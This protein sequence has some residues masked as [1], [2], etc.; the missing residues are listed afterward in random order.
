MDTFDAIYG[1]RA[2]KAFDPEHRLTEEE[3]RKLLEAAVQSPTSFNIQHWRFVVVRNP[4]LR[5]RIR[6]E[7][8]NDQAQMTDASLLVIV[9]ADLMA[10]KKDTRSIT[11]NTFESLSHIEALTQAKARSVTLIGPYFPFARQDHIVS[12]EGINSVLLA[13]MYAAAGLDGMVAV[14]MHSPQIIGFFRMGNIDADNY[15]SSN[16]LSQALIDDY[17]EL[18]KHIRARNKALEEGRPLPQTDFCVAAPDAGGTARARKFA[19]KLG[20]DIII[21]YKARNYDTVNVVTEVKIIGEV[22]DKRVVIVDDMIDT[23][24]TMCAVIKR[25][26]EEGAKEIIIFSAHAVMSGPAVERLTD[27]Y[28]K[29]IINKVYVTD[30]IIRSPEFLKQNPWY[31][32]VS[33]APVLAE[34]I[35]HINTDRPVSGVYL[36]DNL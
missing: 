31:K 7:F 24:G 27:L 13:R 1:R 15:Y 26:K 2:V 29:K 18:K 32:E 22:K 23:A 20:T 12:R 3:E 36:K 5:Q 28:D 17:P 35:Y 25:L 34:M 21:S 33:L 16:L 11:E 30:S 9:T 4:E 6:S 10:W 14:D 8:G 19:N